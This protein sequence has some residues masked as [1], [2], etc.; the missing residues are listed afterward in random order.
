MEGDYDPSPD[1]APLVLF[2]LPSNRDAVVRYAFVD[3][4]F[5]RR[6]EPADVV[7]AVRRLNLPTSA[8]GPG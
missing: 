8:P 2:G 1:G 5:T 4:D 6:A 7:A 3:I